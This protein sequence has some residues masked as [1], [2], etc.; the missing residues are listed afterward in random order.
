[1]TNPFDSLPRYAPFALVLGLVTLAFALGLGNHGPIP[2]MEPRFAVA[3]QQMLL[4]NQWL[5]PVKNG[6]PYIEYPPFY[7]WMAL[8]FAKAGLPTLVA[9]RLPNLIALWLLGAAAYG[10]GRH[11]LPAL[12]RWLLAAAAIASPALL[13]NFFI[14]QTDG[15]LVAGT[16]LALWGYLRHRERTV[17]LD[18]AGFPWML[19]IGT[20]LAIFAKGPVGLIVIALAIGG[21]LLIEAAV[22][23]RGWRA[24]PAAI[25]RLALLRGIALALAPLAAWYLACGVVVGWDFVRAAFV[26]GNI[27]RFIA[28]AGGHNNPWWLF[29]RTFWGDYF[30]WSIAFPFGLILAARRLD[31]P[32][33]R[34]ALAWSVTTLVFFSISASKQSKY[35]LPAIPAFVA[36]GLYAYAAALH[37]WRRWFTRGALTWTC[38]VLLLFVGL[39]AIWLPSKS[40]AIVD[41]A[42]FTRFK[43]IVADA[44]GEVYMY[45][46]P[47]SLVLWQLGAPMPYFRDAR[48]LYAAIASGRIE[49]GAYVLVSETDLAKHGARGALTL[50]PA[51]A[52]PYFEYVMHISTKGGIRA[53]RVMPGAATLP[54]PPTPQPPPAPWWTRFDTD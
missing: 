34:L 48:T 35:I 18:R 30:P 40:A 10:L 49:P 9:I 46:W 36:L 47:K 39:V 3:I 23:P 27:T 43:S 15:W 5:L 41:Q 45:R 2:S 44:P 1:M 53:Y 17:R 11:L 20:V 8:V 33:L 31:Q 21:D 51:P 37:K 25:W 19:W 12:P 26:Y 52:P 38:A 7:F 42:D 54:A 32:G 16:A 13:Y 29:A 6:L 14:A 22:T 28:G 50:K 4:H 24:L